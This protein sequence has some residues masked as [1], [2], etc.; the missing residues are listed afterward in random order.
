MSQTKKQ[1]MMESIT[2]TVVGFILAIIATFFVNKL[3]DLDVPLW[4]NFTMTLCF[5]AISLV[6]N[7]TIRRWFAKKETLG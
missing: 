3:H 5:T 6:R 4:K 7:Y 2:Q 1:S